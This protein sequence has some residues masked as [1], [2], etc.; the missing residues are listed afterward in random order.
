[1]HN[2]N[3]FM[4]MFICNMAEIMSKRVNIGLVLENPSTILSKSQ[5]VCR[6]K[7]SYNSKTEDV[8]KKQYT[9]INQSFI[10]H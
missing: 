6:Y 3:D 4:R 9:E 1:M 5:M 7:T 10:Y 2:C 8:Q